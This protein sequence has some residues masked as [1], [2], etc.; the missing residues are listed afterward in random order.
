M[1]VRANDGRREVDVLVVSP[2][3]TPGLQRDHDE[4]LDAL[5][6]LGLSTAVAT[7]DYGALGRLRSLAYVVDEL[8]VVGGLWH[9]TRRALRS[10]R[11]RGVLITT[12]VAGLLL[13]PR[14]LQRS[15]IRF[16]GLANIT[17]TSW[18]GAL[19]RALERRCLQEAGV[20]LPYTPAV[21]RAAEPLIG[22]GK[23]C[24]VWPSPVRPGPE[25]ASTRSPAGLCY[26]NDPEKKGLDL[27]V[28]AW[29]QG[30]PATHRL[31]VTGIEPAVG[32]RFLRARGI[33]PPPNV[34]WCGR[35]SEADYR[36]LSASVLLYLGASRVDEFATTQLEA[37]SDGAL[38]V[39]GPSRGPM[40][41]LDLARALDSRLV[42]VA[43]T[44]EALASALREALRLNAEEQ[45]RYRERARQALAPYTREAFTERLRDEVLPS[46]YSAGL[47]AP[48]QS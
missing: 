27:A 10:V 5:R 41:A 19:T 40:E 38:L 2:R 42:A 36:R 28:E 39:T 44:S 20:L 37:L 1:P 31:L 11:P 43:M 9:A 26:A 21:A 29:R 12:S 46:L 3:T 23:R 13:P 48:V 16:D 35:I 33:D 34:E 4:L 25:P 24:I 18:W 47:A 32:Q 45:A 8:V 15:G 6:R 14:L 17:R 30:A 7:S 22:S